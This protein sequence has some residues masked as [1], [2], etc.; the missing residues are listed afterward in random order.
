MKNWRATLVCLLFCMVVFALVGRLVFLQIV[1]YGFY[2]SLSQGQQDST[3]FQR[4]ERGSIVAYDKSNNE[5]ILATNQKM[6]FVFVSPAEVKDQEKVA[7]ALSSILNI[8]KDSLLSKI[9]HP[10]S[11]YEVI[12]KRIT[13]Q[14]QEAVKKEN[15]NGV[16]VQDENARAYPQG[17]L[18]SH[19]VGFVNQDGEGQYGIEKQ[20][21][22]SLKGKEGI[23][24]KNKNPALQNGFD[25]RLTID[26]NIQLE[27]ESLLTEAQQT[28]G[29]KEGTILVIDPQDGK[30][31][32]LAEFPSFNS[33]E[34]AKV[35]DF[36]IFQNSAVEKIFEPGS[37]FK[38]I[39]MAAAIDTNSVTPETTYVDKGMVKIG[40]HVIN[41]YGN[42]AHGT[43]TMKDVLDFS[44]NTGAVFA[45]QKMGNIKFLEYIKKFGIFEPTRVDL[46][47]E[48]YS[49]NKELLNG[50]EINYATASFGQGIELTPMQ[51]V[52]AYSAI[53]NGG[54]LITPFI[55]FNAKPKLSHPVIS[56]QTSKTVTSMLVDV[57]ENGY[58]KATK[59][60]GYYIAGKTGTAQISWSA[61]GIQKP[62]YSNKTVQSFIGYAPAY[63]PR[64]LIL[65][66]LNDPKAK[67]AEYSAEPVFKKLAK[68]VID[69]L[70][71]PPDYEP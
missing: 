49:Q 54:T 34:Y 60:P 5:T 44:V 66:K 3:L 12:K 59:I 24:Q 51:L 45:E 48:I 37:V 39:T 33:N 58:G 65:V 18:A 7:L 43:Q 63:N 56:G 35:K 42:R 1:R 53:A 23:L 31:L 69:Y 10:D 57:I 46:P 21:N 71:I 20:F 26:P 28:V 64:F 38:A 50:R 41:N 4:G 11:L 70:E 52:R 29:A 40:E 27:A 30:I 6:P 17:K 62:G 15:L 13:L 55:I 14:E 32:A 47:G 68:Y 8:R 16:Y 67:T 9:L 36:G 61:L 22:D 2:K 25:V 19:I